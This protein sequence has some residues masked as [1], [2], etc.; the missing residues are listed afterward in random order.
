[1]I[2]YGR[3][4]VAT[5]CGLLLGSGLLPTL[6]SAQLAGEI[7]A[8]ER[9]LT[10][11]NGVNVATG[12]Y[13]LTRT[14]LV[15]GAGVGALSDARIYGRQAYR[16]ARMSISTITSSRTVVG[17]GDKSYSFT[18]SGS[19]FLP[20]SD[21][22]RLT[23]SGGI[24]EL[25]FR[26]GTRY[27]YG[28]IEKGSRHNDARE[29]DFDAYAYLS[30]ITYPSGLKIAL[31]WDSVAYCPYGK[32][33]QDLESANRRLSAQSNSGPAPQIWISR[34]ASISS[35]AGYVIDYKYAGD[36]IR[37]SKPAQSEID[38]WSRLVGAGGSNAVQSGLGSLP[39]ITYAY[40]TS[41][42]SG[43][44][45][46]TDQ[47]TDGLG[48]TWRYTKQ[49]G[50]AGNYEAVR[51]PNSSIDNIRVNLDAT[52]RVTSVVRDGV[53]W[54]YAFSLPSTSES[55]LT[56]T[57][58]IGRTRKYQSSVSV[59]LPTRIEDEHGRVTTYSYDAAGRVKSGT[60]PIGLVTSYDYDAA[61]NVVKTRLIAADGMT[62]TSS[63]TYA[64]QSCS[65]AGTC[66]NMT[67]STDARGLMTNYAYDP[68][69]G[70]VT[71]A[72]TQNASGVSP[73]IQTRYA[74]VSGVWMPVATW[75][76]RTLTSCENT[77]DAVKT[78]TTY[79]ASLSTAS[80]T[81]GA[82]D[83]S[84][85]ATSTMTYTAAGDVLTVD[86][87]LAGAA[88]TTRHYYDIAR[89]H[90]GS[91]GPDPDGGGAL[92]RR[93]TRS[94][95][96]NW[97]RQTRTDTGTAADQSD[98]ALAA[99]AILQTKQQTLDDAGRT[100]SSASWTGGS[101]H[102]RTDYAYDLA[103]RATCTALRMNSSTFASVT[104]GC[105]V[106]ADAGFGPDRVTK[107]QYASA[108]AGKPAWT[109]VTSGYGTTDAST[110]LVVETASGK[111]ASVTDANGNTTAY[112]YD[113]FDRLWR[114]CYQSASS[115]AC[116]AAPV[117]YEQ[118]NYDARGDATTRR[119]RD[120]QGIGYAY[121]TFGRTISIDRPNGVY[122]ET[123]QSYA[124]DNVG[125]LVRA[126][127]SNQCVL[128][129][130]YDALGHRIANGDSWYGFGNTALQFDAAGRRTRVTWRDGSHVEYD[131]LV[132]GEM[133]AIR[134]SAGVALVS[135]GYDDLGQRTSLSRA[136][137][138]VTRY[139]YDAASRLSQLTQDLAGAASDL[140]VGF[141]HNPASQITSRTSSNDAYAWSGA[142][143]VDRSYEVNGLN[144]LTSAGATPL[145]YD[146]R[147]NLTASGGLTYTYTADNQLATGGGIGLAY[148]PVGRLFNITSDPTVNTTLTYEG[149][150]VIAETDQATG[151]LLRRYVYGP[152][153][154]EPLIWYEGPG[155]GDRRWLHADERGSVIAIS[156]DA[157]NAIRINTY[158]EFGIPGA[159]NI[160]RFQYT[161]QKWLPALGMYDYKARTYSPTLGRFMQTD[162][163]G[164]GDGVNWYNY[165]G[166]DPINFTDPSGLQFCP[167]G[168]VWR[169]GS[170]YPNND[171]GACVDEEADIVVTGR[172]WS[173][174]A[175]SPFLGG[176]TVSPATSLISSQPT[177]QVAQQSAQATSEQS[178]KTECIKQCTWILNRPK[179][180]P[181]SDLNTW[182]FQ[183]CVNA[184]MA[185]DPNTMPRVPAPQP[186]TPDSKITSEPSASTW[187][188]AALAGTIVV[189][190]GVVYILTTNS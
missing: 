31:N 16:D 131:H 80:I 153:S 61:G 93:A 6:A 9:A 37:T 154:D 135:F 169:S 23:A 96:D 186:Q 129:F 40:S 26:D 66:N 83:G 189:V 25:H 99:M 185:R 120:G 190:G 62:R 110:E 122:W 115:A 114:T 121:D 44:Y 42:I 75:A 29:Q 104:D 4:H 152:G 95:Y 147:G 118:I 67:A 54:T 134:D 137:G 116:A 48:R 2:D 184:C 98:N 97:G 59:G 139:V 140:S 45:V 56:V 177:L 12:Q 165:V 148:D 170:E 155:F 112:A 149:S 160:G 133:N 178:R 173:A 30:S 174:P 8:P 136:N 180:K 168:K 150:D 55:S 167:K 89:Q 181:G 22:T 14:D 78:T 3:L 49:I 146:G 51:R 106:G 92:A 100:R 24:Y 41:S 65:T 117:D 111:A 125:N 60:S 158:D 175:A 70:G 17:T 138:T 18:K 11:A 21:G 39:S 27:I 81:D 19:A 82:G 63:A 179:A 74:Q 79:N 35:S 46:A 32:P 113:G 7:A 90:L 157:G 28:H 123:D 172:L 20:A 109:S 84:V 105:S 101:V 77:A 34:L 166:G 52:Y 5:K 38:S 108:G 128:T 144:Q 85:A 124:Y 43:G 164:Y 143:V 188:A 87:P 156:D 47:V 76:C 161:G 142:Y 102:S 91:V 127:D 53:T 86:G 132:T 57:D 68:T 119:R 50:G 103:G 1:M 107:I 183:K 73:N 15:I 13:R 64:D 94:G 141:G 162:P 58:P 69:H 10:D 88:D 159:A 36:Y 130:V 33:I 182:D 187:F 151:A 71:S 145:G 176:Y 163:I 126:S 72:I 171:K